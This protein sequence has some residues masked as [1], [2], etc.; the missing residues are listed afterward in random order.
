MMMGS[1]CCFLSTNGLLVRIVVN[2]VIIVSRKF[3]RIA[4]LHCGRK[5]SS[6]IVIVARCLRSAPAAKVASSSK[7]E[8]EKNLLKT[9]TRG[10]DRIHMYFA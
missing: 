5:P 3:Y 7:L 8:R 1:N 9:S 10:L 6:N 2:R 4:Q